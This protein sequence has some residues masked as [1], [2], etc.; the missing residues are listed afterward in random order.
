MPEK[1]ADY[2]D[3]Y[4]KIGHSY[5]TFGNFAKA[6]E[7]YLLALEILEQVKPLKSK[8]LVSLYDTIASCFESLG[9][10][11]DASLFYEK[12]DDIMRFN[13]NT[14]ESSDFFNESPN[15]FD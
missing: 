15:D 8:E 9:S 4:L 6:I 3:I 7:F 11:S 5:E 2:V 1:H 12:S 10:Q 14:V 13:A